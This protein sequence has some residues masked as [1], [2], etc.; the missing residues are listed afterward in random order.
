M[1][2]NK[3][4]AHLS[5]V[6]GVSTY[7]GTRIYP[8]ILPQ[9][10]TLPAITFQRIDTRKYYSFQGDNGGESPRVQI[11]IWSTGYDQGRSIATAIKTA[12]D[13]ATAYKVID[14]DQRD[15]YEPDVENYRIQQDFVLWNQE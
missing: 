4:Y 12:M 13:A 15:L 11:D 5:T 6:S 1:L 2:E 3:I 10:P 8:V 9:D 14:F 7:I